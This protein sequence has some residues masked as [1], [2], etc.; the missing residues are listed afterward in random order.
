M[1]E[2]GF[3]GLLVLQ[4]SVLNE[5]IAL[6]LFNAPCLEDAIFEGEARH[7]QL[8]FLQ[9]LLKELSVNDGVKARHRL[10]RRQR[11]RRR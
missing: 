7:R 8:D 3:D 11:G 2:L 6:G 1:D 4:A 9:G 5:E 10:C